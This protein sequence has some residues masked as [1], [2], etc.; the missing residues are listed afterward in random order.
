MEI[1]ALFLKIHNFR[2][3]GLLCPNPLVKMD[4]PFGQNKRFGQVGFPK[5]S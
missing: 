5:R 3:L 1:W 2:R 4:I